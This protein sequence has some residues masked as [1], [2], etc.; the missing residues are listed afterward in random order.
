MARN[1]QFYYAH[2]DHLGRPE[3]LTNGA[4]AAVWRAE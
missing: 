4:G 2:G 3:L 1:G